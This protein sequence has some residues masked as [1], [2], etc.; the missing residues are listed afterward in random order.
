MRRL[1]FC[2]PILALAG[3]SEQEPLAPAFAGEWASAKKGCSGPRVS[4]NK[5]GISASGMPIDGLTFTSSKVSGSTADL[6][7]ELS[8][9]AQMAVRSHH[10]GRKPSEQDPANFEIVAT[11]I[12]SGSRV[13]PT[14]VIFRDKKTRLIRAVEADVLAIVTLVRCEQQTAT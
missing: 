11:L 5:S 7:M 10:A 9:A 1:A 8:Q 6:T 3:C 12:A 14:N 13:T 4:I 2:V